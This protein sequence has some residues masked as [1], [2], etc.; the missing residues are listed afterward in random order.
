MFTR[1]KPWLAV[2]TGGALVLSL[3][4]C[5]SEPADDDG[6]VTIEFWSMPF[7]GHAEEDV[8]AYVEEFNASQDDVVV[9]FTGLQ[10]ADGRDKI[11]Q[12]VGAGTG[13]DV[14]IMAP[15]NQ[16][17]LSSGALASLPE[18]G[19][20]D[21][22]VD[23]FLDIID[24]AAGHDGKTYGVPIGYY[25]NVLYYNQTILSEYGFD[26]PPT[27]WDELKETAAA[28][29]EGSGGDVMGFQIKGMDDHL[30][31]IN[32]TWANF[33]YAAGACSSPTTSRRRTPTRPRARRRSPT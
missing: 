16:D 26:A 30:N 33:F 9:E 10:W 29:T 23:P 13:P 12:A 2:A 31:A 14:F 5:T 21:E 17:F 20:T 25:A 11:I 27:T 28:I 1:I 7:G 3:A 32:H 4:A 24:Y 6:P 15:V 18:L 22:D 8:A 19:Y